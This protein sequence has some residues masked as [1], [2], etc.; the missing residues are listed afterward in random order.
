[1]AFVNGCCEGVF[2]IAGFWGW[3]DD[4]DCSLPAGMDVSTSIIQ[5]CVNMGTWFKVAS[6]Q[7]TMH[8]YVIVDNVTMDVF[9]EDRDGYLHTR[10]VLLPPSSH[11][12]LPI[13]P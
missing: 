9:V 6:G 5:C 10:E 13:E 11:L 3:V 2:V 12:L 1:M 8:G 7:G 4:V